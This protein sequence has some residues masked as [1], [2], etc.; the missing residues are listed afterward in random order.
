MP[1]IY[2]T[3]LGPLDRLKN[4]VAFALRRRMFN[5]FM[6]TVMPRPQAR[7]ADFG[8][9]GHRDHP[10]HQFFESLYPYP[11]H[12]TAIGQTSEDG[13]WYSEAFPGLRYLEADLRFIPLPDNY[14]DAGL[15][16]AV[17][18]HAGT[19]DEQAALVQEVCRVCR[20]VVFTTP[21]RGFPVELHTFLPLIHWLPNAIFHRVLR[22]LG[23][24]AL[25]D[26]ATLNPVRADDFMALFPRDRQTRLLNRGPLLLQSNLICASFATGTASLNTHVCDEEVAGTN[27]TR[28]VWP[29]ANG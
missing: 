10:V 5:I 4:A 15:C 7:V 8:V 20:A 9:S 27:P 13:A 24:H 14:F 22:A 16:N 26:V 19:R 29:I 12:V 18:E 11:D 23:N 1:P 3:H 17:V 6:Q 21:N 28:S 25:G 2:T